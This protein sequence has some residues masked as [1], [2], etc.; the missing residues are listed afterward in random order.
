MIFPQI[1]KNSRNGEGSLVFEPLSG[2]GVPP[3]I[4]PGG[5]DLWTIPGLESG[6]Y[7]AGFAGSEQMLRRALRLRYNVF[8]LEL[9]EGLM[10]SH[11]TGLDEDSFDRTMSHLLV[12]DR[13]ANMV[14]GTYRMQSAG[15]GRPLYCAAQY[16]LSG[17]GKILEGSVELGRACVHANHRSLPVLL[18][19]WKG[20]AAFQT[21]YEA[22]YIFGC[23][24]LTTLDSDDGWRAMKIL[25]AGGMLH[26]SIRLPATAGYSCGSPE[27]EHDLANTPS[28]ALPKLFLAYMR[29]G[30][31]VISEPAIDRAFGTVDFL[32]MMDSSGMDLPS[33]AGDILGKMLRPRAASA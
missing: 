13:Q 2:S 9:N 30:A 25:R 29:L 15:A 8:N 5:P 21:C 32:V 17:L 19:L 1:F 11:A 7:A 33:L 26:E 4:A 27:R 18:L 12:F 31:K 3:E 24:S 6:R 22:P 10:T 23:C 14:V 16:D 20:I 28:I